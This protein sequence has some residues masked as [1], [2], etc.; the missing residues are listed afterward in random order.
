M[1]LEYGQLTARVNSQMPFDV[2]ILGREVRFD[3]SDGNDVS[4]SYSKSLNER[5]FNRSYRRWIERKSVLDCGYGPAMKALRQRFE[6]NDTL[7]AFMGALCSH[8]HCVRL[9]VVESGKPFSSYTVRGAV[10]DELCLTWLSLKCGERARGKL[11]LSIPCAGFCS[12]FPKYET[13][14]DVMDEHSLSNTMCWK[15]VSNLTGLCPAHQKPEAQTLFNYYPFFASEGLPD[16]A[17]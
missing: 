6:D 8:P 7:T 4:L 14:V 2:V 12:N 15:N 16:L 11:K 1:A 10:L 3:R 17:E 13:R 9:L 5:A